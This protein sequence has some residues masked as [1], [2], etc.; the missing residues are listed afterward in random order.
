MV[1][2]TFLTRNHPRRRQPPAETDFSGT[3]VF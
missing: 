3:V 2:V 1:H